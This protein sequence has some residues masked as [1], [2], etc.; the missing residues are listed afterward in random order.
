MADCV[1][2]E[3]TMNCTSEATI[4]MLMKPNVCEFPQSCSK[5]EYRGFLLQSC[6]GAHMILTYFK[7]LNISAAFQISQL[8]V[9]KQKNL[10]TCLTYATLS[11]AVTSCMQHTEDRTF[12]IQCSR[13]PTLQENMV[14][15]YNKSSILPHIL[16]KRLSI[17]QKALLGQKML[18]VCE[19]QCR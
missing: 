2:W 16:Q 12:E 19:S 1:Y 5:I 7:S 18:P 9:V 13:L 10:K 4:L 14:F 11:T 6:L 15:S 17:Q 8:D 3:R